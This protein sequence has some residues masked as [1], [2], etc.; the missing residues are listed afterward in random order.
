MGKAKQKKL[1]GMTQPSLKKT[2][3]QKFPPMNFCF[4]SVLWE[5]TFNRQ[6]HP[7]KP[8]EGI[9]ALFF[10]KKK[11]LALQGS[12][13]VEAAMVLPVFL[14]FFLNLLWIIEIFNL[15]STLQMALRECDSKLCLYAHAYDRITDEKEDKGLEALIENVAF[16]YLYVKGEVEDYAGDTYLENSPVKGGKDGLIYADSSIMQEG[17][18]IDLVVSYRAEPFLSV[19]GFYPGWFYARCYGR[20]WTGYDVTGKEYDEE[21]KYVYV[22]ENASVYH[23][24]RE[25]SHIQ[26]DIRICNLAETEKLRN[27]DGEIYRACELCVSGQP[28]AVYITAD[29]NRYHTTG[30]CS[31]LRR[32]VYTMMLSQAEELYKECSRCGK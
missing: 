26:L 9:S 25:C 21:E 17:D 22:A 6:N 29:G 10:R 28:D 3:M 16:S 19:A 18:I 13:T 12:M 30:T 11:F 31:G 23:W 32:T 4:S 27:T 14:F 5:N 15:Q 24:N 7:N 2:N 1:I 20:A 8:I